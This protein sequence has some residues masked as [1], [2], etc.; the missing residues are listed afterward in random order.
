MY[1][2]HARET[3]HIMHD[4]AGGANERYRTVAFKVCVQDKLDESYVR[5]SERQAHAILAFVIEEGE[6]C[7]WGSIW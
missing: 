7:L 2:I 1:M 6:Q 4:G 3:M 5:G